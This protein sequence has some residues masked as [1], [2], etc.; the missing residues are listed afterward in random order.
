MNPEI[1]IRL[2]PDGTAVITERQAFENEVYLAASQ[3]YEKAFDRARRTPLLYGTLAR[4][5]NETES[6]GCDLGR[7][8][9][10]RD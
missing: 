7:D 10:T 5:L 1:L 9:L 2:E 3:R 4:L 6:E 8:G